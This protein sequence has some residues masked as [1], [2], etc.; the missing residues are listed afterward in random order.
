[1]R[2]DQPADSFHQ[3]AKD[4]RQIAGVLDEVAEAMEEAEIPSI[5]VHVDTQFNHQIPRLTLW[6]DKLLAEAKAQIR[7][8]K[9]GQKSRAEIDKEYNEQ[10]KR[11]ARESKPK[12]KK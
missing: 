4:L 2:T 1:M 10:R 5:L 6:A 9:R 11:Q 7:D 8:F 12:P 3:V